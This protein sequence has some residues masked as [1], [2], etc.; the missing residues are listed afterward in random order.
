MSY[1]NRHPYRGEVIDSNFTESKAGDP[2]LVLTVKL[3]GR[4]LSS[5]NPLA[6]DEACPRDEV[7]T[8]I[9]FKEEEKAF[10]RAVEALAAVGCTET[11]LEKIAAMSFN[12][13]KVYI[14][15]SV[16]ANDPQKVFWNIFTPRVYKPKVVDPAKLKAL[17]AARKKG[18]EEA[19]ARLQ[20]KLT[21]PAPF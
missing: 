10:E 14:R 13:T 21:A 19:A 9:T 7:K 16:D 2:M 3:T 20:E 5:S 12:D 18:M 8:Y 15:P 6:G 17:A 11:D 1:D 4:C